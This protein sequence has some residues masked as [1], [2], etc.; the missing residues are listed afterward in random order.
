MKLTYAD[1]IYILEHCGNNRLYVPSFYA[2]GRY[3]WL[4][5]DRQHYLKQ[6]TGIHEPAKAEY[7]CWFEIESNGEM[8]IH[9]KVENEP[10]HRTDLIARKF[11]VN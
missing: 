11:L 4:P 6:I 1:V 3:E 2:N 8:F 9:S 5:V 7:P 10:C